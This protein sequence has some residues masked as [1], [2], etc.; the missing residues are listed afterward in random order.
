[1]ED[2]SGEIDQW[3]EN[4]VTGLV[5]VKASVIT[6]DT[7]MHSSCSRRHRLSASLSPV[8]FNHKEYEVRSVRVVKGSR[9]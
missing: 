7:P 8:V 5:L 2:A 6:D 3:D 1:M 9:F 4:V